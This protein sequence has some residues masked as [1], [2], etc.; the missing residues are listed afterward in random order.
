MSN[1]KDVTAY[2]AIYGAV[3]ATIVFLWDLIKYKKDKPCLK[4]EVRHHILSNRIKTE[5]KL[6]IQMANIG[7]RPITVVASG[8]EITPPL[9]EGNMMTVL[10]P[11]LPKELREGQSHTTYAN[12]SE[13]SEQQILFG[14]VRDATGRN[15]KSKKWPLRI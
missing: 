4:V 11:G 13:I 1:T 9:P 5:Q 6:G 3:L 10:D 7:R 15:W 2:I 8:F 12:T 14:W